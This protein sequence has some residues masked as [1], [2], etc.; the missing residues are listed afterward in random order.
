MTYPPERNG[1][2]IEGVLNGGACYMWALSHEAMDPNHPLCYQPTR[3]VLFESNDFPQNDLCPIISIRNTFPR[4]PEV[5][6][7]IQNLALARENENPSGRYT[8][9]SIAQQVFFRNLVKVI[10]RRNNI[11]TTDH[12]ND[13]G[14]Y[15][16]AV[17][18]RDWWSVDHWAVGIRGL[19]G[20]KIYVQKTPAAPL[21][22]GCNTIWDEGLP[23]AEIGITGLTDFQA[24]VLNQVRPVCKVC[25]GGGILTFPTEANGNDWRYCGMCI[26]LYCPAH[27]T[28]QRTQNICQTCG[29][30]LRSMHE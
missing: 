19:N 26:D 21:S 27:S 12:L 30:L 23:G 7:L 25:F 22:H 16:I 14:D 2:P 28:P 24:R 15:F 10:L 13:P 4:W 8:R 9:F 29:T 6:L 11:Q 18:S 1:Y 3:A 5:E 20:E 17:N